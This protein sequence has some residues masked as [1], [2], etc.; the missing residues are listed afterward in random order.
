MLLSE[1][2][3]K[4][5]VQDPQQVRSWLELKSE[6]QAIMD[7]EDSDAL[8]T[9]Q[10]WLK[11]AL[12]ASKQLRTGIAKAS[13]ALSSFMAQHAKAEARKAKRSEKEKEKVAVAKAKA[14]SKVAAERVKEF[15]E[16]PFFSLDF[17]SLITE[18]VVKCMHKVED[19]KSLKDLQAAAPWVVTS[20]GVHKAFRELNV[21][22]IA[23]GN[24]GGQYLKQ[25]STR[26]EGRGQVPM[27]S[28]EGKEEADAFINKLESSILAT[29]ATLNEL[30][31]V[32]SHTWL[33]GYESRN[34]QAAVTPYGLS[35]FRILAEGAV[36]TAVID[37]RE[38][39]A[40]WAKVHS[41]D[42]AAKITYDD[43]MRELLAL[44]VEGLRRLKAAGAV[45]YYIELKAWQTL[46]VPSGWLVLE[47]ASDNALNYGIRKTAAFEHEAAYSSYEA[48]LRLHK[49]SGSKSSDKMQMVLPLLKP[50]SA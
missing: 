43:L 18:G 9:N 29:K 16:E 48:V 26:A 7:L 2:Q 15:Q 30:G 36:H 47:R 32:M 38:C 45:V 39:L 31:S 50:S 34:T 40:A 4:C 35:V 3:A 24:F 6:A 23:L 21:V 33:Y 41:D 42:K 27:S 19:E 12:D 25:K 44:D 17:A 28:K 5:A 20:A 49:E 1:G 8:A 11:N 13:D 14:R 22:Q 10:N 46:Y 37:A